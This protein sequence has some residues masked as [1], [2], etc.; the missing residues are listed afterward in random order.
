[1]KRSHLLYALLMA[2]ALMASGQI[3][4]SQI[5]QTISYQGVL[6]GPLGKAVANDS[7]KFT[8]RLYDAA[9]GGAPLWIETQS[10]AVVNGIFKV[11]LG[12][13]NSLRLPFDKPYWLGMA[14]GEG[15]EFNPRIE[16]TAS[17]YSLHARSIADSAV[18]SNKIARDQVVRSINALRE[19]VT[20][21]AGEN[22]KIA[23]KGDS[24]IISAS[25][26][27]LSQS[28]ANTKSSNLQQTLSS[29]S[30]AAGLPVTSLN[31]L[32]G[33]LILTT[34]GGATISSGGNTITITAGTIS[35]ITV[36][37]GLDGG[38]TSG[39][40]PLSI[41]P[42][43]ITTAMLAPNAVTTLKINDG[44]VNT[45]DLANNAVT[46]AKIAAG[47]VGT[48]ELANGAVTSAKIVDGDVTNSKLANNAVT[49]AKIAAGAVTA[50]ELANN[51]VTSAKILDGDVNTN[52][53]ANNA[54][55][56]A[57]IAAAAVT[58]AQLAN[59]AVTT[60]KLADAAVTGQ[61]IADND[62]NTAD[63]AN[64]AVT[65]A[66][67]A[68]GAVGTAALANNA[69]TAN[70]IAGGEV[71]KALNNLKDNVN[72]VAGTNVAIFPSGG[73]S[74]TISATAGPGDGHS[75]DA[76]DGNPVDV[77]FVDNDGKVGVGTMTPGSELDVAGTVSMIGLKLPTDAVN[78][79]VLTSGA[80]GIGTWLPPAMSGPGTANF[81]PKYTGATTLG[82]SAIFESGGSV[83]IGTTDPGASLD[84]KGNMVIR[85]GQAINFR[86][87]DVTTTGYIQSAAGGLHLYGNIG[88]GTTT[89]SAALHINNPAVNWVSWSRQLIVGGDENVAPAIQI[90]YGGTTT[91]WG[92][93]SNYAGSYFQI[94]TA[95]S[96]DVGAW[97]PRFVISSF[98]YVGIGTTEPTEQL[99][100]A[101]KINAD[102]LLYPSSS[103]WKTNIQPIT[104]ALNK[105]QRLH[106]VSYD[107]K[108]DGKPSIGLIAEEVA[109]VIPEVVSYEK[110]SRN[111]NGLDYARLVAVLIEAVKEQ[112]KE[113]DELKAFV[114][115][116][117]P[118]K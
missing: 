4:W 10:V 91:R 83:G 76:A 54:V 26:N 84:L 81:I 21:V 67:I 53:L 5:P 104:G 35:G 17:A 27:N 57:K 94:F 9:N 88:I 74:L 107:W 48:T 110:D 89:P 6:N 37:P 28:S 25:G 73:N 106:G 80:G 70:K 102:G 99:H 79:Y 58:T 117:A 13:V 103:R 45:A 7:Y 52:E 15:A 78:D 49:T 33:D 71:V 68:N 64:N 30:G 18:T 46:S 90:G 42:G 82:N 47:A 3:A 93:G 31:G 101:G 75:L 98:G 65:A 115:S 69:V 23:Q 56:S 40:V 100:V 61:K 116:I 96:D 66:K 95:Y 12:S 105:L 92:I 118:Q 20:L 11:N 112:Q 59:N 2:L 39:N 114:K 1:M 113:I 24:L 14:I 108:A 51:A 60:S 109:E 62:V 41:A 19:N 72:L 111:A 55:T 29:S 77:V 36:G 8:F 22:V 50:A 38:G 85:D 86:S 97:Y 34:N 87:N 44:D 43:G 16:L 63:L 32:E